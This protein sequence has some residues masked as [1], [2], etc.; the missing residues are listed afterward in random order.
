M[1][2]GAY[3]QGFLTNEAL[4]SIASVTLANI[5]EFE[6]RRPGPRAGMCAHRLTP[7]TPPLRVYPDSTESA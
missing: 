3:I 5:S 2:V 1:V 7:G 4:R 6:V